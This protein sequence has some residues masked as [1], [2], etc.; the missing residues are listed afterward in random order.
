V[1]AFDALHSQ[2]GHAR[3][4]VE[5]KHAHCIAPIKGNHPTLHQQLKQLPWKD[6]PLLDKN[7]ATAHGRDEIRGMKI[8][9]VAGLPFPMPSRPCR[10]SGAAG[11]QP[12]ARSPSNASTPSPA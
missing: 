10:S 2:T 6:V 1:V 11:P 8:A 4:L 5:D 7:R 3:F 9:T 12:P